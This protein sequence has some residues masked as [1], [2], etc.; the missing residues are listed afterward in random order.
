MRAPLDDDPEL[1]AVVIAEQ[2]RVDRIDHLVPGERGGCGPSNAARPGGSAGVGARGRRAVRTVFPP[3]KI[4]L[5]DG[6]TV[7]AGARDRVAYSRFI[8]ARMIPT[9]RTRICCSARGRSSSGSAGSRGG[10]SGATRRAS[11]GRPRGRRRLVLGT[12]AT[13]LVLLP[14]KDPRQRASSS[15]AR[16]VRGRS[17]PHPPS[18][19]R[20]TSTNSS[21]LVGAANARAV[22][23]RRRPHSIRRARP[24]R[25]AG[26]A[27][28]PAAPRLAQPV[29]LGQ[30]YYVR[31]DSN[32]YRS[33]RR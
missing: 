33:I 9:R 12:F 22:R 23:T 8:F 4:P 3:R 29:R 26:V 7:V 14:P 24:G 25:D 1:P 30:D 15:V 17:C 13:R 5:E 11:V 16:V 6:T 27:A 20:R 19:R 2:C 21:R 28:R 10:L 18:R 32:D 31:V